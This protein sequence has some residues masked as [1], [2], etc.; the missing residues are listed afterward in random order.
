MSFRQRY[1]NRHLL[2]ELL[3]A[4]LF[5]IANFAWDLRTATAAVIVATVA[6]VAAALLMDRRVPALALV[7]LALVLLLGGASLIFSDDLFIKIKP[8][9]GKLLFASALA[10]GLLFRPTFL[11]RALGTQLSLSRPGWRAV[12]CAWI[13]YALLL[14]AANEIVW[15]TA[16]TD[17]WVSYTGLFGPLSILGYVLITRLL[18]PRYWQEAP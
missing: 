5:V 1:L 13:A 3:P 15:R 16:S 8:T 4:A 6:V 14:A 11:E 17:T 9:I 12:T 7:T 2:F 10:L 18:A